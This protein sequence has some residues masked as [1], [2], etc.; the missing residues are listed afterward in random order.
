MNST[1]RAAHYVLTLGLV[2]A[3]GATCYA[4]SDAPIMSQERPP[5]AGPATRDG[6]IQDRTNQRDRSQEVGQSTQDRVNQDRSIQQERRGDRPIVKER[7]VER[8]R[9]GEV[10]VGGFGGFTWGHDYDNAEGTGSLKGAPIGSLGLANSVVYGAKIGYFHP[11]RLNWLGLEIE[12]FNT[13]PHIKEGSGLPGSHLRVTT[14]ALNVIARTKLGCKSRDYDHDT[15]GRDDLQ[16]SNWSS[17]DDNARCPLQLYAG[18][19]PGIFFAET[20]NQ[21]GRSSD[22]GRVG[23]N[24]LAGAKYF[25]NRH[26]AIYAEYKFNYA[27]FDFNQAQGQTAGLHG[28]YIASHV[29]GGLAWH[30]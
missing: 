30:F 8:R 1:R 14:L 5:E 2:F 19:G 27:Q 15:D 25:M 21:F 28:D 17:L 7:V 26:L 20:S 16:G 12:G 3:G 9:E 13:T 24:A 4:Q 18:V 23:L 11:G 10:Y 22:N 6:D 29:V